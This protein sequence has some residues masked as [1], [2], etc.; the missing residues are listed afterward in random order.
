[1]SGA[2]VEGGDLWE[3][4]TSTVI[5][6]D[7]PEG[8]VEVRPNCPPDRWPWSGPIYVVTG[9]NP[10]RKACDR[11]NAAA[12]ARLEDHLRAAGYRIW[13]A[14]GRSVDG[15]WSELSYAVAGID[16][17][18]IIDL[19]R[20]FGQLAVFVVSPDGLRSWTAGDRRLG[21]RTEPPPQRRRSGR[22]PGGGSCT[23]TTL[24]VREPAG[25]APALGT[26]AR[27]ARPG[28]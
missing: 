25:L 8:A 27:P 3:A 23:A 14:V 17:V 21:G 4:F 13:P 28:S 12:N 7:G 24:I 9:W 5:H 10:G 18:D 15:T 26:A 19:A 1:M 2:Y 16:Q 20:R 11:E 6:I 22:A